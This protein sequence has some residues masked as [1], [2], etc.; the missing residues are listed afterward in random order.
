MR[1]NLAKLTVVSAFYAGL[2]HAEIAE[3][4]GLILNHEKMLV[5]IINFDKLS[6]FHTVD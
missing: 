2:R 6:S 3:H 4:Q 5:F 1:I